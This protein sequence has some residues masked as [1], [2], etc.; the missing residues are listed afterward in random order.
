MMF[1]GVTGARALAKGGKIKMLAV[2][3]PQRIEALPDVPTLIESGVAYESTFGTASSP[4]KTCR[5][6]SSRR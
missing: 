6:P 2:T 5:L 4:R 3:T 1:A